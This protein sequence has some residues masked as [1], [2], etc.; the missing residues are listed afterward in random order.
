MMSGK[1]G[2]GQIIKAFGASV[3]LVALPGGF[4]VIKAAL[5]DLCGLTRW[6]RDAVWPA[7]LA[8]GLITLN[9]INE[10]F[11]VDLHRWTP[12][13]IM[14][15]DTVSLEHPQILRPWNPI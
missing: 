8:Y 5:D 12:S 11:D 4:R 2:V 10:I 14:E 15:W 9:L 6:T 13:M 3:T 7:Q 1:N